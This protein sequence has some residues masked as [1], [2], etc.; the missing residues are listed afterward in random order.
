M[1]LSEAGKNLTFLSRTS[2]LCCWSVSVQPSREHWMAAGT[3]LRRGAAFHL[4]RPGPTTL[5]REESVMLM[6]FHVV[7][8]LLSGVKFLFVRR[9]TGLE[10]KY[11]RL[12][13]EV[14]ATL[15]DALFKEGNST[16]HDPCLAAKRQYRLGSL[17]EKKDRLEAKHYRWAHRV[18][19]LSRLIERLRGWKGRLVPYAVGAIDVVTTAC[20]IDYC[21]QGDLVLL[22]H[23]VDLVTAKFTS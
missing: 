6:V 20:T 9:A 15:R 23:L 21:S 19:R 5:P 10:R 14:N 2:R 22:R 16:R 1:Y 7:L 18:E 8:L 11:A 3:S 4:G 13:K 12:A 17:V